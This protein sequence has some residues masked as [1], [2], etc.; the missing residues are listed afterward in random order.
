MFWHKKHD[1][2][3][4]VTQEKVNAINALVE[5]RTRLRHAEEMN[6]QLHDAASQLAIV[7][8]ENHFYESF[9]TILR[10]E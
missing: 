7:K 6:T 3:P 4:R 10:V 5:A 1:P 2:K 8:D 9:V